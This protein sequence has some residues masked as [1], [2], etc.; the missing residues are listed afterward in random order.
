MAHHT[1]DDLVE[2][3]LKLVE[4]WKTSQRSDGHPR[5]LIGFRKANVFGVET[6]PRLAP[7]PPPI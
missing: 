1:E 2:I 3:L 7:L 6:D 5:P 4:L